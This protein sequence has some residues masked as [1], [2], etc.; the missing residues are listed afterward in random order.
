MN[1]I[2][3]KT[4]QLYDSHV[5]N[6]LLYKNT[7]MSVFKHR[8][9]SE[10]WG[11]SFFWSKPLC[12]I[13]FLLICVSFIGFCRKISSTAVISHSLSWTDGIWRVLITFSQWSLL[14]NDLLLAGVSSPLLRLF[15]FYCAI[16]ILDGNFPMFRWFSSFFRVVVTSADLL[17]YEKHLFW[18]KISTEV[19]RCVLVF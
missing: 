4:N 13:I 11:H 7:S 14:V 1:V 2:F 5:S 8:K 17:H 12:L 18:W 16:W 10:F 15:V 6:C 3:V 9:M 19:Y